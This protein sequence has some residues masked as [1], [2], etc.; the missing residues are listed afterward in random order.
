M[1]TSPVYRS[2][3][4]G[5]QIDSILASVK[6]KLDSSLIV[7]DYSGGTDK[8]ASA[9]LAKDLNNQIQSFKDPNYF[10]NLLLSIPGNNLYTT[11]EKNKL[12]SLS[13]QFIGSFPDEATR[14]SKVVTTNLVGDE[15]CFVVDS[16]DQYHTSEWTQWNNSK[17]SW[18]RVNLYDLG[19]NTPVPFPT[20]S[21]AV[22]ASFDSKNHTMMRCVIMAKN[23][24][25]SQ[26]QIVEALVAFDGINTYVSY[27][28]EL[29]NA[30]IFN[31]YTTLSGTVVNLYASV[32]I[33]GSTISVKRLATM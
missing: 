15:L 17:N 10:K 13:T 1:S 5:Q 12:A 24:T 33:A 16:G 18:D 4:T 6:F 19:D 21:N 14:D 25:T 26:I 3:F 2:I 23:A 11:D 31:L 28:G 22:I 27:F 32:V 9:E 8:I 20:I 29:G 7:N 30:T